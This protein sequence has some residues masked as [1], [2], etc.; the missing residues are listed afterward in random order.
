MIDGR[1]GAVWTA[2]D[3]ILVAFDFTVVEGL[4]AGIELLA[5]PETIDQL[6]VVTDVA[7]DVP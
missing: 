7:S 3:Q 6:E 2:D 5:D 1:P 4:I